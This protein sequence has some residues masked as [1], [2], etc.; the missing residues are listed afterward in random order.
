[1]DANSAW[2]IEIL[3]EML[4][5]LAPYQR[6]I[7]M[8]E[9]PFHIGFPTVRAAAVRRIRC[10]SVGWCVCGSWSLLP[11]VWRLK[12]LDGLRCASI[13]QGLSA[14]QQERWKRAKAEYGQRGTMLFAD[15]SI[16]NRDDVLALQARSSR[17]PPV[18]RGEEVICPSG[19]RCHSR[20]TMK[21]SFC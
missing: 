9:Q 13:A 16:C 10:L 15:E 8:I 11:S 20:L 7:F 6:R 21:R 3:E 18:V 17:A 12:D 1:M 19:D 4:T 14:E 5:V 2:S